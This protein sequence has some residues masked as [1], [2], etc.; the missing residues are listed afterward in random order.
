[1]EWLTSVGG[2]LGL[3]AILAFLYNKF[4]GNKAAASQAEFKAKDN[5]LEFKEKELIVKQ[6]DLKAEIKAA[7]EAKDL[8]PSEIED[9]WNKK[10]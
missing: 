4:L 8:S 1:M 2:G 3:L 7:G 9:A 6:Q 5:V 10:K